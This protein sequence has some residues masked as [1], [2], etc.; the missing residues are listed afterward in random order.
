MVQPIVSVV[1]IQPGFY[2]SPDYTLAYGG[3]CAGELFTTETR[4]PTRPPLSLT[5]ETISR[6]D[7]GMFCRRLR[8]KANA[9]AVVAITLDERFDEPA[10]EERL[11]TAAERVELVAPNTVNIAWQF[12][13]FFIITLGEVDFW[14]KRLNLKNL[15]F[16]IKFFVFKIIFQ[17]V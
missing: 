17:T 6:T 11:P 10:E 14:R 7:H 12:P 8:I 9:G 16:I 1:E 3:G 15:I 4:E 13:Q 2:S 5:N